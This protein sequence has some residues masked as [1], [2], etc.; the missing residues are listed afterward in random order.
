[1]RSWRHVDR[2]EEICSSVF[3]NFVC[4]CF[5]VDG[6]SHYPCP[7]VKTIE[8]AT[9]VGRELNGGGGGEG[10]IDRD[11]AE[12]LHTGTLANHNLTLV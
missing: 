10:F 2:T 1:M 8:N 9:S 3:R 6:R 11:M 4:L 12:Q 7:Q 5:N